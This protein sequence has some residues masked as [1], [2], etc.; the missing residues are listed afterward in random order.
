MGKNDKPT[1]SQMSEMDGPG[2]TFLWWM[3]TSVFIPISIPYLVYKIFYSKTTKYKLQGKVV[4]ITG[5]SSGLGEALAHSFYKAGCK[6]ILTARREKELARVKND[7][8][9]LHPTV[10]TYPPVALLLDISKLE[11]IPKYVS[12][13]LAIHKNVDI[14]VNNAGISYRGDV[15]STKLEVDEQVM[16]VNYFGTVALTKALLPQMV[17]GNGGHIVAVS[18]VQGRIAVP[19]R[20]A[21]AASKHALQAFFDSLRAELAGSNVKVTV[22][23]P[24]YIKTNLSLNAVT[25]SGEVYGE[26]DETTASGYSPEMVANKIVV[27]VAKQKNEVVIAPLSARIGIGLR[28]VLPSLYFRIMERRAAKAAKKK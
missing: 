11:D 16:A 22:V 19:H 18:S 2:W 9:S 15:M 25:G 24:G 12:E 28:T 20:S 7:L 5:A 1:T 10:P 17:E 14:L 6:V 26:M 23:S 4:L 8:L 13:V 3:L 21:Y 27:S